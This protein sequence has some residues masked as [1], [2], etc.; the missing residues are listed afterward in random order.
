MIAAS[1]VGFKNSGKTTL[2]VALGQE[3]A[4]RGVTAAAA[5]CSHHA[6]VDKADTDTDRLLAAYGRAAVLTPGQAGVY[7]DKKRYLPDLLP[8]LDADVLIVEGGK[9]LTWLP[10]VLVLREES[11]AAELTPELAMCSYGKVRAPG[12]LHVDTVAD[13]ADL[14]LERGFA[15]PGLDCGDCGRDTCKALAEQI[16]VGGATAEKCRSGGAQAMVTVNGM[17]VALNHYMRRVFTSSVMGMLKEFKGY[18]PGGEIDIRIRIIP[19]GNKA[20]G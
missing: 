18:S 11:E 5:K 14:I 20:G 3:L 8:L 13:L 15:L 4:R 6:C 9:S 17:P 7:W 16:V 1:I 2:A 19:P 10:R 12:K